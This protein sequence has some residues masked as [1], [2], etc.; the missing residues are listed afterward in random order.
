[1]ICKWGSSCRCPKALRRERRNLNDSELVQGLRE[2]NSQAIQRLTE[3]YLPSIWRFV[4]TQVRGDRHLAEDIVSETVLA[5]V[6]GVNGEFEVQ[7]VT[8]WLRT[9]AVNKIRDHFR[10][11][12]RVQH[13]L[14]KSLQHPAT[15]KNP[16]S[17]QES[18]EQQLEVREIMNGLSDL[19]RLALEWKYIEQLSVREIAVRFETTE[20][21]VESIL[22]RARKEFRAASVH[23]QRQA[24]TGAAHRNGKKPHSLSDG[25]PPSASEYTTGHS[26]AA[27]KR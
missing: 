5:L 10:A 9:V 12:A 21:A 8:A 27:E 23:R 25:E 14:D 1:M 16:A 24:E 6:R 17:C 11:A 3:C 2:R 13:L 15:E 4:F 7:N 26:P 18:R 22:F 20:K 19:H